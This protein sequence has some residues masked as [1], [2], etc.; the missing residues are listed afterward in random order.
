MR[1][2]HVTLLM[3]LVAALATLAK[4]AWACPAAPPPV[5][6]IAA[7]RFY[8]D[9]A[10]SIVDPAVEARNKASLAEL[11]RGLRAMIRN[12]DLGLAGDH[13][14]GRCAVAWMA[15]WAQGGA[16]LGTMSSRQA[17]YERK[18]RTAGVG[19]AYLKVRSKAS[20]AEASAIAGWLDRLATAVEADQSLQREP[21][22]HY[23][24]AGFAAAAVGTATGSARHLRYAGAAF[25]RGVADVQPDGTLP[26]EMARR[27]R[28]LLY[29]NYALGPLVLTAELAALRGEDWYGRG[30]G[31]LH[32]LAA[33]TLAGI[34]DPAAFARLAGVPE[35]EVPK[36]GVL[37]WLAFYARRFPEKVGPGAPAGPFSY[38]WYGGDM[39]AAA[40]AWV[41]R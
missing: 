14:A 3:V 27:G 17:G 31:T 16:M 11:D 26:R 20:P 5:R 29:H 21:N 23:Y 38:S 19:V 12:A 41:R 36:G 2:S 39:T 10:S 35:V 37:G 25:D 1:R 9:A 4:D 24:W 13:E 15:A 32:R 8:N 30:G 22:N 33:R 6:D 34:A 18:W 7:D 40:R 28:A